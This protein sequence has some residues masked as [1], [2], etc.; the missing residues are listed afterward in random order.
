[1]GICSN[2][3]CPPAEISACITC[4]VFTIIPAQYTC[5]WTCTCIH[6]FFK[7]C[8]CTLPLD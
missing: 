7:D 3:A 1:M 4:V 6:T 5:T 8:N 2:T